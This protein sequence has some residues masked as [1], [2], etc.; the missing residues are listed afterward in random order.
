MSE[1]RRHGFD[2]MADRWVQDHQR[3]PWRRKAV[4]E[5]YR[6][7]SAFKLKEIQTRFEIMEE[8]DVV[9][10]VGAHPGGW[11]QVAVEEVGE[12]GVVIGVDLES[13]KPVD[14]AQLLVGDITHSQTQDRILD[15]LDKKPIN[16]VISDISPD[17]TGR[18]EMDQA[19]AIDLVA[20]VFDFA[21]PLLCAGGKFVTKLF[22]GV[23]V[24]ELIKSVKPYFTKVKRFSPE[25][26]RN[27]S[28]EVYLVCLNHKPWLAGKDGPDITGKME[29]AFNDS[30][31][32]EE[33]Q[34]VATGFRVVRRNTES[35]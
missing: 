2:I 32:E 21:L 12:Q 19:I 11:T 23:G 35:E 9:L 28:S 25:A 31:E 16:V 30:E 17:I 26:S 22:Q 20:K 10:D 14:G 7:R 4:A 5:G 3:D 18:W 34:T 29:I 1:R 33:I 27:S 15:L 13:S 24:D 6:A 8:G